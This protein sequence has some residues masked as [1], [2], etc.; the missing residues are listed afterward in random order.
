VT[1]NPALNLTRHVGASRLPVIRG[2]VRQHG[3]SIEADRSLVLRQ[4]SMMGSS[5]CAS[6]PPLNRGVGPHHEQRDCSQA[7]PAGA[8]VHADS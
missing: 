2:A 3:T 5:R 6:G 1:A 7:I 4:E 8:D